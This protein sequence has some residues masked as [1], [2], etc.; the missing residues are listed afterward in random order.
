MRSA[1]VLAAIGLLST[2]A[3]LAQN[4]SPSKTGRRIMLARDYEI[5]LARS[6]APPAVSARARVLVF[7]DS[8]YVVADSGSNGVTCVVNRSWP[9]ALEPHCYDEE[10]AASVMLPELERAELAHRGVAQGEI[11]REIAAGVLS[12]RYRMPRRPALTYMMSA[13]QVL[14]DDNGR[15]VGAWKPHLM[16]YYP[17]LKSAD[18]GLSSKDAARIGSVFGEGTP[19]SSL[20]V[21]MHEFVP[22]PASP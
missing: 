15:R 17:Y 22:A 20:V 1:I 2:E 16:L 4:G 9:L 5:A 21:V 10:G 3:A 11:D 8:G 13:G 18:L 14:Y 7:T 12:G 6:A 19:G